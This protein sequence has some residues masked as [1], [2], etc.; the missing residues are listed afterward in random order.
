MPVG[1][2]LTGGDTVLLG[3]VVIATAAPDPG[4]FLQ[5]V[6]AHNRDT[7]AATTFIARATVDPNPLSFAAGGVS[8]KGYPNMRVAL[9]NRAMLTERLF[10]PVPPAGVLHFK[11]P[12]KV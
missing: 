1:D 8:E 4:R 10:A 6:E 9:N 2:I 3:A 7:P 11:R 5:A 12:Q